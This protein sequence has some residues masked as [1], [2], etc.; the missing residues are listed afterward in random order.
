MEERQNEA[1]TGELCLAE[2]GTSVEIGQVATEGGGVLKDSHRR[3]QNGITT[4]ARQTDL[5]EGEGAATRLHSPAMVGVTAEVG[6]AVMTGGGLT[7]K[8]LNNLV[9]DETLA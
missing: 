3:A 9:K 7:I 4:P 2:D 5:K 6:L 8:P 1:A